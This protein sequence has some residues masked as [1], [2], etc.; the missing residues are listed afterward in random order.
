[1]LDKYFD[2]GSR[3]V[4][5]DFEFL[6]D[7]STIKPI[8][9]GMVDNRGQELYLVF[10]DA[11]WA[12]ISKHEFLMQEV[13]PW[14][15]HNV[16]AECKE[17]HIG[18]DLGELCVLPGRIIRQR[19]EEFLSAPNGVD[20]LWGWYSAYDHVALA[21]MWGPMVDMPH[22]IPWQTDDIRTLWKMA[23]YPV[24]PRQGM[25]EHHALGDAR[26]NMKLWNQ[27]AAILREMK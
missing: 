11:P 10:A 2:D 7:G 23:G 8:S 9:V 14:L 6:E 12:E 18:V 13:V 16:R 5:Y 24:K 27:C 1:M 20:E 26:W 3:R 17:P 22:N 21:Q 4:F 25:M 15:P 19:V